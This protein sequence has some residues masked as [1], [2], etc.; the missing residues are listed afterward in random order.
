MDRDA[1]LLLH[2]V[3]HGGRGE[4]RLLGAALLDEIQNGVGALVGPLG[5]TRAGQQ[6]GNPRRGEGRL[7]GVEGLA[8][9]AEG[10][11]DFGDRPT[12]DAMP[13]QHLVFDLHQ[14]VR[15]EKRAVAKERIGHRL[16]VRVGSPLC[17]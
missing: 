14:V 11:G 8:A 1:E 13:A 16:R 2:G 17:T 10:A 9:D 15:I 7:R 4:R 5:P 3:G 6:A 12:V